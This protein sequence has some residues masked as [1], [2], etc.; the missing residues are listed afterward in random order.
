MG[1]G[2]VCIYTSSL[3]TL[4]FILCI[5]PCAELLNNELTDSFSKCYMQLLD[6]YLYTMYFIAIY[7]V[8]KCSVQVKLSN[9]QTSFTLV[10]YI[11]HSTNGFDHAVL[12]IENK[13]Q[14][15]AVQQCIHV[16]IHI[17]TYSQSFSPSWQFLH[18]SSLNFHRLSLGCTDNVHLSV[19]AMHGEWPPQF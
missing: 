2:C 17:Y 15:H 9:K 11:I 18:T 1:R 14:T 5:F 13:A 10:N 3:R 7:G 8:K 16:Y 4:S 12:I 6:A 19:Y